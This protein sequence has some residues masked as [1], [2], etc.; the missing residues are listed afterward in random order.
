MRDL[1]DALLRAASAGA[2]RRWWE[3][4]QAEAAFDRELAKKTV[5]VLP[6]L[7]EEGER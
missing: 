1:R 3:A 7:M 5:G 4:Q 2:R 6:G